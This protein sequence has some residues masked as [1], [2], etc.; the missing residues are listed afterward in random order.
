MRAPRMIFATT[1]VGLLM[2]GTAQAALTA[3][4][5]WARW[6]DAAAAAG[7]SLVAEGQATEGDSLRL[8]GVTVRPTLPGEGGVIEG[9]IAEVVM[10]TQSDGSVAIALAPEFVMPLDD[11]GGS[12]NVTH[13]ALAVVASGDLQA[14]SYGFTG[15]SVVAR[16]AKAVP[17]DLADGTKASSDVDVSVTAN[18]FSGTYTDT[19]AEMRLIA[20]GL[21][22]AELVV[23]IKTNDPVGAIN[24]NQ[25]TTLA[26]VVLSVAADLPIAARLS[27]LTSAA[28]LGP[29]VRDGLAIKLDLTQGTSTSTNVS[30]TPFFSYDLATTVA[31]GTTRASFDQTGFAVASTSGAGRVN[32]TVDALPAPVEA[33]F[34]GAEI[35]VR[36]PV[37][38]TEPQDF[39]YKI[40]FADLTVNE[41]IWALI[42]PT[43]TLPRDAANLNIDAS[44]KATMDLVTLIGAEE[45]GTAEVPVPTIQ[46]LD[47]AALDLSIAGAAVAGT[48]AFTFDNTTPT[49]V[50]TGSANV[51]VTG[52]N[53]LIDK[54][55]ALGLITE[56][57]AG[58]ARMM[59]GMFLTPG[60]G[61]DVLTTAIEARAGGVFVNGMQVQ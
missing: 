54:L 20:A 7:L 46:S 24:N 23:G 11:A 59:M 41:D 4:Q 37:A 50:P 47:L 15:N 40:M 16:A 35:D 60:E 1:M 52:V 21:N 22:A 56:E 39:R 32:A 3:D 33:T 44:G 53:G 2:T 57:D 58:G 45:A 25:V 27:D 30:T 8:T 13:D 34:A 12:L 36:V 38:A 29:L 48:G 19:L 55:I 17:F 26:D 61:E 28:D 6:Q 18:M 5:V 51:T 43:K 10:T 14:I 31:G 49:P 9:S 42:D